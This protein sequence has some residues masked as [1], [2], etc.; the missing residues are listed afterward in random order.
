[1]LRVDVVLGLQWG[2]EGKGKV[3]DAIADRYAV[4]ARFQG[5]PNAGHT[6]YH[7]GQKVVLHQVPSGIFHPEVLCLIGDGVVLDPEVLLEEIEGLRRLGLSPEARIFIGERAHLIL[8]VHRWLENVSPEG[9]K[10]G[11]TKRGIG[12]AYA[13]RYARRGLCVKAIEEADFERQVKALTAYHEARFPKHS[14]VKYSDTFWEGIA[15]LR[16]LKRVATHEWLSNF[17]EVLAEGSQG[18][19]LDIFAGTYPYVTSSHT[20]IAGVLSGLSVPPQAI[21]EIYGV[22]KAYTTRVGEGPFPTEIE[23]EVAEWLQSRGQE[24][25]STTGRLRRCG[26]LDLV[27]LRYAVKING[28]TCL[29]LTKADVLCGLPEVK[30]R[31]DGPDTAPVYSTLPGW[32]SLTDPSF[33]H[34]LQF[35]EQELGVPVW[36]IST[37]PERRDWIERSIPAHKTS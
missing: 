14:P 22:T 35:I 24:R 28:V 13:D 6:L 15:L 10:I 17:S 36:G 9:E 3:V 16:N 5:G 37:G 27:A 34:F 11:T 1:M 4:V 8:P 21:R 2:D 30:V 7:K 20:T 26:W 25:G 29:A 31:I 32:H 18:T 19:M 33:N 12:P 23:G